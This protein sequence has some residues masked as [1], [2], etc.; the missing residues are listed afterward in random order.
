MAEKI[1]NYTDEQVAM[2][3]HAYVA[4]PTRETVE[5][6]ATALGKSS[7]SIIAKLSR[8]GL[9]RKAEP[10]TKT[11]EAVKHKI[12]VADAIGIILNLSEPDTAS[13]EK[14]NK[15]ALQAI[16]NALANSKPL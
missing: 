15:R 16:F 4:N 1:A 2:L 14:A 9:Y 8:M 6:L 3:E 7:R 5:S 13:L 11:G 12:A 10:T